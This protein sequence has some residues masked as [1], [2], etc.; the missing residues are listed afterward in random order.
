MLSLPV[1]L[2]LGIQE[3]RDQKFEFLFQQLPDFCLWFSYRQTLLEYLIDLFFQVISRIQLIGY[4]LRML[5]SISEILSPRSLT[6]YSRESSNK[7]S[8]WTLKSNISF[9]IQSWVLTDDV[10]FFLKSITDCSAHPWICKP[11]FLLDR[12]WN[13]RL[14]IFEKQW[15]TFKLIH[16]Y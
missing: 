1:G 3:V 14:S 5:F 4:A 15:Q 10:C 9:W 6:Y 8:N 2:K 12:L 11:E 16:P 13:F 7:N